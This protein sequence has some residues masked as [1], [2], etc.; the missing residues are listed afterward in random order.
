MAGPDGFVGLSNDSWIGFAEESAYGTAVPVSDYALALTESLTGRRIRNSPATITNAHRFKEQ[1]FLARVEVLGSAQIPV[2]YAGLDTLFLHACGQISNAGAGSSSGTFSRDYDLTE[3]G[4]FRNATSPS[5]T[6]YASRGIVGSGQTNPSVFSYT[7]CMINEWTLSC[8]GPDQPLLFTPT[9][10]GQDAPIPSIL[11]VTPAPNDSPQVN[12][13]EMTFS[14]GGVEIFADAFT[15]TA[16]KSADANRRRFGTPLAAEPPPGQWEVTGSFGTEWDGEI[17]AGGSTMFVD[18]HGGVTRELKMS[19][20][21]P[22][23][24]STSTP[25][26]FELTLPNASLDDFPV[27]TTQRGRQRLTIPTTGWATTAGAPPS[28]ARE[29]RL[30]VVNDVNYTD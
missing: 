4:R 26:E 19:F 17:R 12:G 11:A 7:G 20:S 29:A 28:T 23:I 24:P 8:S 25:Y 18:Y 14:W 6:L 1:R 3:S 10:I 27:A 22:N 9:F 13:A 16:R 30:S 15:I 21:G 2:T 5:L